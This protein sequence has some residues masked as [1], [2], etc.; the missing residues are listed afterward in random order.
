MMPKHKPNKLRDSLK[1][2]RKYDP[3]IDSI[4]KG[5]E[6]KSVYEAV[7]KK[8]AGDQ[9]SDLYTTGMYYLLED[10]G[11][12]LDDPERWQRLAPVP[13]MDY[14]PSF[15]MRSKDGRS[16]FW[17]PEK[18]QK[19]WDLV[20]GIK[21][22]NT[23]ITDGEACHRAASEYRIGGTSILSRYNKIKAEKAKQK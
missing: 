20:E 11:I 21:E 13:A 2:K 19:L 5:D 22:K 9:L 8:V 18:E 6:D 14:I 4:K 1:T 17:T 10:Y 23:G 3:W 15:Q 7:S 16:T 12:S